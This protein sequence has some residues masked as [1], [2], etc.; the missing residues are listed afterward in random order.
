MMWGVGYLSEGVV[1]VKKIIRA[2][3]QYI[4]QDLVAILTHTHCAGCN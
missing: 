1:L 4:E 3:P 2:S